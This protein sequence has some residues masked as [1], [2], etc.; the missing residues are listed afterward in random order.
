MDYLRDDNKNNQKIAIFDATNTTRSRRNELESHGKDVDI[1]YIE[2]ICDDQKVLDRNY[3][4]KLNSPGNM[5]C[6][7]RLQELRRQR[8][9]AGGF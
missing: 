7:I 6:N 3:Q 1:I 2:S 8:Q 4:M 9:S 5:Q